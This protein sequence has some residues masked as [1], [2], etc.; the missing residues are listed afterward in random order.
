MKPR[1]KISKIT[2]YPIQLHWRKLAPIFHSK[3]CER[4]W[5]PNMVEYL[6]QRASDNDYKYIARHFAFPSDCD[7]C[8][9]R[10]DLKRK[11]PAYFDFV[12]HSAC[13]WL[14]DMCLFVAKA[15]HPE[16]PWRIVSSNKHSTVWNGDK[17]NPVLFDA[18]FLALDVAP[19]V[20]WQL[21]IKGRVLKPGKVLRTWVTK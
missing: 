21:A 11:H 12:C 17:E 15:A 2:Y 1:I 9:W 6:Q 18:N 5:R 16:V 10:W 4:I 3:Q 7:S 20:A 19:K 14:V 13:H 8:D